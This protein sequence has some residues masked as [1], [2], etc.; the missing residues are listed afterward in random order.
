MLST[1]V[2]SMLSVLTLK[3]Q[4]YDETIDF[5]ANCKTKR[6]YKYNCLFG[7]KNY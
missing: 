5:C 2:S 4:L 3:R 7:Y 6:N 1:N